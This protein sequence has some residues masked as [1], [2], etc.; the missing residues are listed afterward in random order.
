MSKKCSPNGT[1]EILEI[2]NDLSN[3]EEHFDF[4]EDYVEENMVEVKGSVVEVKGSVV[5]VKESV[6]YF[7]I[8]VEVTI[9]VT[10]FFIVLAIICAIIYYHY[11]YTTWQRVRLA[12]TYMKKLKCWI[13]KWRAGTEND[14]VEER[15]LKDLGQKIRFDIC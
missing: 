10:V 1:I 3:V 7:R 5:E 11:I 4:F 8:V 12:G 2:A 13:D 6:N 15:E 14:E 9:G